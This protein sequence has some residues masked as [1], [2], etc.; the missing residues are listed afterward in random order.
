M[1]RFPLFPLPVVLFPGALLPLHIFE[2]RYR[3]MIADCAEGNQRFVLLPPGNDDEAPAS[4]TV[5]T[6]ARIRA[7][8]ALADGRSNIAVSGEE[9]VSLTAVAAA[10]RPYLI[11]DVT[12]L[13]DLDELPVSPADTA[14]LLALGERYVVALSTMSETDA[15]ADLAVDPGTLTFQIAS[16]TEWDFPT[17]QHFLTLRSPRERVERLLEALPAQLVDVEARAATH[18]GAKLNGK[19]KHPV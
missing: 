1:A 9:R 4:G 17:K 7:V 19:G 5:G 12:P 10:D 6:I 15:D 14:R 18:R 11:G 8:Q 16:L 3:A 2:P 13:D